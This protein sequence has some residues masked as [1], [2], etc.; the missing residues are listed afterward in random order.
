MARISKQPR[1]ALAQTTVP[2]ALPGTQATFR[3]TLAGIDGLPQASSTEQLYGLGT[4]NALQSELRAPEISLYN[5]RF[6]QQDSSELL[7]FLFEE[8]GIPTFP[9]SIET[10][11]GLQVTVPKL[12]PITE[13]HQMISLELGQFVPGAQL[14]ELL[15]RGQAEDIILLSD[16]PVAER[17]R[18]KP[19][20]LK[21]LEESPQGAKLP[22]TI[23]YKLFPEHIPQILPIALQR[24]ERDPILGV[25]KNTT[26]I[27]PSRMIDMPLVG[28]THR[29][30]RYVLRTVLCHSGVYEGG[31]NYLYQPVRAPDS[32][33]ALIE[34]NDSRVREH[35]H[36]DQDRVGIGTSVTS[37]LNENNYILF[38]E[39]V[40]VVGTP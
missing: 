22:K 35:L 15:I 36:P 21:K 24:F 29:K 38:Y 1:E 25:K 6:S 8:L 7:T 28:D 31:H 2:T 9:V 10:D 5:P 23:T 14:Q 39:Y 30:A 4:A 16:I 32:T 3:T 33:P 40:G 20:N 11:H 13:H 17:A 37:D 34:F 12:Q 19:K 27:V 26:P 18:L